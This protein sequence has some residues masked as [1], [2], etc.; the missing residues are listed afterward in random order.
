[1]ETTAGTAFKTFDDN[2]LIF[3]LSDPVRSP[4]NEALELGHKDETASAISWSVD[5]G[6][7]GDVWAC[8]V[9]HR[10]DSVCP[11]YRC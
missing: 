11:T 2:V 9:G 5:Y 7:T 8:I 4:G 6:L 3:D 1:M 10:P